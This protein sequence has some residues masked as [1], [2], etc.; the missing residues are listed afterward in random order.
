MIVANIA[1]VA[2]INVANSQ[3]V[4]DLLIGNIF[5]LA[6]FLSGLRFRCAVVFSLKRGI[7]FVFPQG[8]MPLSG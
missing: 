4:L 8:S 3:L 5:T 6:T 1:S 2:S 7:G